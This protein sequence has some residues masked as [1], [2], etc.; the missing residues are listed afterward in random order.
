MMMIV[1]NGVPSPTFPYVNQIGEISGSGARPDTGYPAKS[2]Y[3]IADQL[4]GLQVSDRIMNL[5]SG[6]GYQ[7]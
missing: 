1:T 2:G 3:Q 7:I 6:R 4:I 5:V